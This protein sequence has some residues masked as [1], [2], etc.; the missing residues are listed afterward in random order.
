[1]SLKPARSRRWV[2]SSGDAYKPSA[3]PFNAEGPHGFDHARDVA[4]SAALGDKLA[5]RSQD[6]VEVGEQ[7]VVVGDPVEGGCRQHSVHRG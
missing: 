3:G 1:M 7:P 5:P 4:R 6:P 2:V